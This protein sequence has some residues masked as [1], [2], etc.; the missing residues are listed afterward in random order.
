MLC[1]KFKNRK[2]FAILKQF[3]KPCCPLLNANVHDFM[4]NITLKIFNF[5]LKK[6]SDANL[7]QIL[8]SL[9]Y[10]NK[11]H[12]YRTFQNIILFRTIDIYIG[13]GFSH[14]LLVISA[15]TTNIGVKLAL[16]TDREKLSF[17]NYVIVASVSST[18]M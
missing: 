1:V 4:I 11:L 3:F 10:L 15:Q 8:F 2:I 17:I 6:Y 7:S 14:G 12:Q 5:S 13:V 9:F 16:Q 18:C